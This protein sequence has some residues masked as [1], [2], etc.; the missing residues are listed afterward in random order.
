[1][2]KAHLRAAKALLAATVATAA[3]LVPTA[4]NAAAS[5]ATNCVN[6]INTAVSGTGAT[7]F[8]STTLP[9]TLDVTLY[10]EGVTGIVQQLHQPFA[11]SHTL[12]TA[13]TLVPGTTYDWSAIYT[14]IWGNHQWRMGSFT[15]KHRLVTVFLQGV[16]V[17]DKGNFWGSGSETFYT[18]TGYASSNPA[19]IRSDVTMY[20]GDSLHLGV[21][22]HS[23]D[24]PTWTPINLEMVDAHCGF[25][26]YGLGASWGYGSDSQHNWVTGW[27]WIDTTNATNGWQNFTINAA[28]PA[29]FTAWGQ[30]MVSYY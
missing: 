24:S 5:C 12:S 26:T 3:L 17:T 18:R 8:S 14:D 19:P 4:A 9:T 20:N 30:Y 22:M 28:G 23:Y 11:S 27:Y 29:A 25:C 16:T 10:K 7:W 13:Q 21:S 1:M 6:A 15:T 2:L